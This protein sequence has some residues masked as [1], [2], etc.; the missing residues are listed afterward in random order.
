[1]K[2][3]FESK[4]FQASATITLVV[5]VLISVFWGG[6]IY[7][8]YQASDTIAEGVYVGSV[9]VGGL[10]QDQALQAVSDA[11]DAF[12]S[13][14]LW[15]EY[16]GKSAVVSPEVLSQAGPDY[17]Y[18]YIEFDLDASVEQAYAVSRSGGLLDRTLDR[19]RIRDGEYVVPLQVRADEDGL[20]DFLQQ[21]FEEHEQSLVET[22][23]VLAFDNSDVQFEVE[24]GVAGTSLLYEQAVDV[25]VER[26]KLLRDGNTDIQA[27]IVQPTISLVEAEALIPKM[28]ALLAPKA[29]V[30]VHEDARFSVP[31]T[32]F[33][34]WIVLARMDDTAQLVLD[35]DLV[36]AYLDVI[37]PD[38]ETDA[39]SA[40][41]EM[42]D[43]GRVTLFKASHDG[44]VIDRQATVEALESVFLGNGLSEFSLVMEVSP[45]EISTEDVNDFGISELVAE[46]RTDFSGSPANRR[47]NITHGVALIN[48]K[49]LAP[50]EEFSTL[51]S[52]GEIDIAHGFKAELVIKGNE[53]KPEAGGGL[54]QVSTTLFRATLNAGL[55]VTARRN[56]SYRVSYYEPPVGKDATIYDPAPDYKFVNDTDSHMLV[57]GWVEGNEVVFQLWGKKDGREVIQTDPVVYNITP[58]PEPLHTKTTD[59]PP[60]VWKCTESAHAGAS[61]YF[62]YSV[63]YPD[64]EVKEE[65]FSSKYRP[66]REV[67]LI[68]ATE[69]DIE[70]EE[71]LKQLQA[72][73]GLGE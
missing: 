66:W 43:D 68:G 52:L 29:L 48:G 65:R 31:R 14:G 22:R 63:T 58:P 9:A 10:T 1:M 24:A 6:L 57:R 38:I 28:R 47:H 33:A 30:F 12:E 16:G 5:V 8:D 11:V 69:Q 56:H 19:W 32:Q 51:N 70:N 41:F 26:M 7:A 3:I 64:G 15:F 61:A 53:T 44:L 18:T 45:P 59:L 37:A 17:S 49:I 35:K 73:Q 50:G 42:G 23:Y 72:E 55:P 40:R 62:D 60:G 54:C 20:V 46:G 21:H 25:A 71:A 36:L 13:R 34:D 39:Q 2:P 67:C 4:A 27:T